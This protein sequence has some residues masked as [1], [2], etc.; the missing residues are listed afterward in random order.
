[1]RKIDETHDPKRL[2]WVTGANGHPEFP[3]QNLPLGVVRIGDGPARAAVAIGDQIL[4]LGEALEAGLFP[5]RA[6]AAA[7]VACA[8]T[9]NGYMALPGDRRAELRRAI[10]DMLATG[11]AAGDA[12]A[13]LAGRLLRQQADCAMQLP[14]A[15][16]DY[17]DFFAGVHHA[18]NA[19]AILR[20]PGEPLWP[21]YLHVPVGY[22]GRASSVEPSGGVVVRPNGQR[23]IDDEATPRFGPS[24]RLD[25]ELEFGAWIGAGNPRGQPI[26]I[27]EAADHI[28]GFS[29]LND[30][31]ARDIQMW[32][33]TPLGPFLAKN[34][35]TFVSPWMVTA[36]ALAPFFTAQPARPA[37]D[38][39]PLDYLLDPQDQAGGALDVVVEAFIRT[40]RM[41]A[42]AKPPG[43]VSA[44]NTLDLY[45]TFAQMVAHHTGGGCP[46]RPGDLFG[47]GTISAAE[48]SGFGSLIELT[49]GGTEPIHIEGETRT[50]LQDGDEVI[51]QGH[52]QRDGFVPIGFGEC[53]GRI[54][55]APG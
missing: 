38:P 4:D 33:A 50:F 28:V 49:I 31:S 53:R 3:I 11:T 25:Y 21:N 36:E 12:A 39:R 27:S 44:A 23:L 37:G 32:E 42:A 20:G 1:M 43:R 16:G 55:P 6:A 51:F 22:H 5:D 17:T 29:L 2:S 8:P 9:L 19:V 14:A 45:W 34:F 15:V 47:S 7:K 26:P 54:A 46:L 24:V 35:A 13:A 52:C 41:R 10:S 48:R 18:R 40:E 30:W